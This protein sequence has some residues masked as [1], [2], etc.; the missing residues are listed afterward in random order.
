MIGADPL[1]LT[2][3]SMTLTAASLP[4]TVVPLLVLMNDRDVLM[5]QVN[6]WVSNTALVVIALLSIVLFIAALPLQMLG[7]G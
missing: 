3:V 4:L 7:G 6:G 5:S 2:N 1:A